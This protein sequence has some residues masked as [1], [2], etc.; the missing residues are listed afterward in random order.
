MCGRELVEADLQMEGAPGRVPSAWVR[1]AVHAEPERDAAEEVEITILSAKELRRREGFPSDPHDPMLAGLPLPV[2]SSNSETSANV[3]AG[4]FRMFDLASTYKKPSGQAPI[5]IEVAPFAKPSDKRNEVKWGEAE[6]EFAVTA[7]N[8]DSR[9]YRVCIEYDGKWDPD[10]WKHLRLR[11]LTPLDPHRRRSILTLGLTRTAPKPET[12]DSSGVRAVPL[13]GFET[14]PG[15]PGDGSTEP[16]LAGQNQ[17]RRSRAPLGDAP[18][19]AKPGRTGFQPA[20]SQLPTA[21][22]A[23]GAWA[24]LRFAWRRGPAAGTR[25]C[26]FGSEVRAHGRCGAHGRSSA[27]AG[28]SSAQALTIVFRP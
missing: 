23:R 7:K 27:N 5:V 13:P 1:L 16:D 24:G 3:P 15:A 12:P 2:S 4:G 17:M 14:G 11:S 20:F 9:R 10:P 19:R 8:A 28:A 26:W 18:E 22:P 21:F 25:A 6:I